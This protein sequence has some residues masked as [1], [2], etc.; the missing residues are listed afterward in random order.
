VLEYAALY[1]AIW[2]GF[3]FGSGYLAHR[4]PQRTLTALPLVNDSYAWENDGK[5]YEWIGVRSWK[6]KL[7]EAG[8]FYPEGFSK[9]RL[10][11]RDAA[12]LEQF[13]LETSRAECSHWLTWGL[14]LTF[15]AWNPWPIGVVMI[16]Y[17]AIVNI[18]FILIQR[19]NR[20][21]L[22]RTLRILDRQRRRRH[23]RCG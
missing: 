23:L 18:P 13:V 20:C 14:S 7:P 10:Q 22:T 17:G 1:A 16:I 21:R 4:L 3:H 12:Y 15:F 11:G 8:A 2:I 9:R 19:Y 6:D 5:T